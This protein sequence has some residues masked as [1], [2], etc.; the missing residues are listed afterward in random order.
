[1]TMILRYSPTS[2][3]VRKVCVVVV[4]T[5]LSAQIE[6]VVTDPWD[7]KTDLGAQNPLG[8]VPTL[9]TDAGTVLF[10][11]R[12]ICEFLDNLRRGPKLFPDEPSERLD[13]LRLQAL[14]DGLLDAAVLVFIE[15]NRRP[16]GCRW[17][18]WS[19]RQRQAIHRGLDWLAVQH[20][21]LQGQVSIGSIAVGCML[22]YLDFRLPDMHWQDQHAELS[23]WYLD[24]S[25]RESM[26]ASVPTG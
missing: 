4:E 1:M 25:Q 2:P 6:K 13:A 15:Q 8:K 26:R 18:G 20:H 7:P 17:E 23:R 14:A 16:Q 24:F 5:G 3:Y 11:S 12:V 9:I 21:H 19:E 22:G 10:D